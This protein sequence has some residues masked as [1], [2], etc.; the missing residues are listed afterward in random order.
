MSTIV[1]PVERR[2]LAAG[3]ERQQLLPVEVI[4]QVAATACPWCGV[5]GE[6]EARPYWNGPSFRVAVECHRCGQVEEV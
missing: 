5:A 1:S 6:L 3:Y 4:N 2:I